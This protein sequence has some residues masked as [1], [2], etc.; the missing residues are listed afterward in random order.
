MRLLIALFMAFY[1]LIDSEAALLRARE[2]MKVWASSV[3][4]ALFPFLALL[5]A[6]TDED[7]LLAYEKLFGKG[8][9]TLFRIPGA[10]AAPCLVGLI[11]GSPAGSIAVLRAF[12]SGA[13]SVRDA[14]VL[15]AL[16]TGVGPVFIVSSVGGGMMNDVLSGVK[17][18]VCAVLSSFLTAFLVSR[19]SKAGENDFSLDGGHTDA[20]GAIRE[21]V[22]GILTVAGYMTA[23]YVFAGWL[24]DWLY[25]FFEISGG[26]MIASRK[27]SLLMAAS[28]IGFGGVCLLFQNARNLVKA[29]VKVWEI[30][31]IKSVS[32]AISALMFM[33]VSR[34]DFPDV[35][36]YPD[37]YRFSCLSA[38]IMTLLCVIHRL[39]GRDAHAE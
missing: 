37:I 2:G 34:I 20:P 18:F 6:L 29:G 19:V 12:R 8:M 39:F 33:L 26:C 17:L 1:L 21:A 3:A 24:P 25:A 32:G 14:R 35:R 4:P 23:F 10:S 15:T 38:L 22:I 28:V 11:A 7:A 13:I 16:S 36:I 27:N 5:P 30:A 31:A 9:K